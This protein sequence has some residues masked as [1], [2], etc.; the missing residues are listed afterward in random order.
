MDNIRSE[1]R[2]GIISVLL[3]VMFSAVF[4]FSLTH[5]YEYW[6]RPDD[7]KWMSYG[8]YGGYLLYQRKDDEQ[9]RI[10]AR[11]RGWDFAKEEAAREQD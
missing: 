10:D 8:E 9:E 1:I 7:L 11:N 3:V 6:A 2:M 5:Y 4:A